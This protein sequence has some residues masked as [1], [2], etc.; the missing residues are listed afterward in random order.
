M[1]SEAEQVRYIFKAYLELGTVSDLTH[2]LSDKGFKTKARITKKQNQ[3]GGKSF[4]RGHIYQLLSNPVY[5]GKIRHKDETYEGE[6]D[7]IIALELWEKTQ[8]RLKDNAP[9]R[10]RKNNLKT[11]SLLAGI[12]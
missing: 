4:C 10:R 8:S 1:K 11:N 7:S 2:H 12:I 9:Q 3:T 5:I 6:H